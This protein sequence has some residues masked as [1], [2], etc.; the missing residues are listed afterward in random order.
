MQHD[1]GGAA[2][3]EALRF[4]RHVSAA[5]IRKVNAPRVL[6]P[7]ACDLQNLHVALSWRRLEAGKSVNDAYRLQCDET[8]GP[9]TTD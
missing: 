7:L 3:Y 2:C 1:L 8:G 4:R 9:W 5:T 6:T